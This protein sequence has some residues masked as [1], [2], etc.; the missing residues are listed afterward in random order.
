[1]FFGSIYSNYTT[2]K[3][4]IDFFT[5]YN[6]ESRKRIDLHFKNL[7]LS[8]FCKDKIQK[9]EFLFQDESSFVFLYGNIY[10]L[11]YL[12]ENYGLD[13]KQF[14]PKIIYQLF[15]I[16]KTKFFNLLNGDFFIIIYDK[17]EDS[18][19][20]VRDHVGIIPSFYL[21]NNKDFHFSSDDNFL[22]TQF[23]KENKDINLNFL[24]SFFK[25]IGDDHYFSKELKPILPAHFLELKCGNL[26]QNKYWYPENI[27]LDYNIDF[28]SIRFE[29]QKLLKNAVDIRINLENKNAVHVSGGLDSAFIAARL[30]EQL[31]DNLK[32]GF[33]QS[34]KKIDKS[35]LAFN[36][37]DFVREIAEKLQ[38]TINYSDVKAIS[39]EKL[40]S[41]IDSKFASFHEFNMVDYC[42][43]NNIGIIFSGYAGDDF[44]SINNKGIEQDLFFSFKWQYFKKYN[45]IK[46]KIKAFLLS[47]V[48]PSLGILD[49]NTKRMLKDETVYFKKEFKRISKPLRNNIYTYSSRREKQ[50]KSLSSYSITRNIEA[51]YQ[52]GIRKGI[53]YRFPLV[54]KRII[55]FM[56]SL[57]SEKLVD[58]SGKF[59]NRI[60]MRD[61]CSN[62][63]SENIS[64][65]KSKSDPNVE[66][67]ISEFY[68]DIGLNL[69]KELEK[70]KIEIF[71]KFINFEK[72]EFD[73]KNFESNSVAEIELILN[74]MICLE[75]CFQH[76]K[77][78]DKIY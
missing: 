76:L 56:L 51:L 43:K 8:F 9:E 46:K 16:E 44:A 63:Y 31:K 60:L 64:L 54:D 11:D 58:F 71:S 59:N 36:E 65:R 53:E 72:L 50:I 55:E 73:I 25:T 70:Y 24:L 39:F 1:M 40:F 37:V 67:G 45:S 10:N 22:S 21:L 23:I 49:R 48:Y 19:I 18:F 66:L 5:F 78:N 68:K 28:E 4:L 17:L 42:F 2:K 75:Y 12:V 29:Y 62:Y 32:I 47:I 69:I 34:S 26:N 7:D 57:P 13:D 35:N 27:N 38:I 3:E 33:S 74:L 77:Q 15:S 6:F 41:E 30:K 52:I 20:L 61:L 14:V